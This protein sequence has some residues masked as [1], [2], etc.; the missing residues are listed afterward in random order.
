MQNG[1]WTVDSVKN[2]F[3]VQMNVTGPASKTA[4]NDAQKMARE[5]GATLDLG[6]CSSHHYSHLAATMHSRTFTK[7]K[8]TVTWNG[9]V[10][11]H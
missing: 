3:C 9:K 7:G 4:W 11:K 5:K 10:W 6:S 8:Y 1:N 2:G